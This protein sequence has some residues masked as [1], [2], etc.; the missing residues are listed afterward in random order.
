MAR[1]TRHN[2]IVTP[3]LEKRINEENKILL[4]DFIN[5]LR[6][7]QRSETTIAALE[8]HNRFVVNKHPT[9]YGNS[10]YVQRCALI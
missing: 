5:Y 10:A 2:V 3:K 4:K 7:L 1:E 6:S 8:N 9:G